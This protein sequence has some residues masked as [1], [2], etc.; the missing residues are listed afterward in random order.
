MI[1]AL[2]LSDGD[3]QALAATI[4][5]LVPGVAEG[6]IADAVVLVHGTPP[7]AIEALADAAGATLVALAPGEAPWRAGARAARRDW[8][9]LLEAGDVPLEGFSRALE[10]FAGTAPAHAPG[11]L[12]RMR[13][14][15]AGLLAGFVARL[16]A[17]AQRPR[18]GD[19]VHASHL[20]EGARPRVVR[21]AATLVR[22]GRA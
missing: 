16:G 6:A 11:A 12:G 14:E 4:A 22:E 2:I 10:R 17:G 15:V 1:S 13:R 19:L 21:L 20:D 7:P 8:L 5:A 3:P 9:L 18:A